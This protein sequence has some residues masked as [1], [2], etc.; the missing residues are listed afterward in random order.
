M[1]RCTGVHVYTCTGVHVYRCTGVQVY[2]LQVCEGVQVY[3]GQ[4]L[5]CAGVQP[6]GVLGFTG[7][8]LLLKSVQVYKLQVWK[9]NL[10]VSTGVQVWMFTWLKLSRCGCWLLRLNIKCVFRGGSRTKKYIYDVELLAYLGYLTYLECLRCTPSPPGGNPRLLRPRPTDRSPQE[11]MSTLTHS[12]GE[13]GILELLTLPK[14][15]NSDGRL[16]IGLTMETLKHWNF[17]PLALLV[18]D[19]TPAN[20]TILLIHNP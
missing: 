9:G 2:N 19:P 6:T 13:I 14:L 7:F 1:Y 11:G 4:E 16:L 3:R 17:D 20:S 18:A 10:Q 15:W 8:K 12:Y 5:R